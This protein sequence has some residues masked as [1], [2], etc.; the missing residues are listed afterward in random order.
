MIDRNH[1]NRR[2]PEITVEQL[3]AYL[4]SKQW[5]EDGKIRSVA[6]IWHRW[7]DDDS[8]VL[9]PCISAKDYL[10][11]I[12][13]A[14][15]SL[16]VYEKRNLADVIKDIRQILSNVITVRIV[17]DDTSDGTIPIND[18]VLLIAK[19]KEL[20]SAAAQSVYA[21]RKQFTGAVPKEAKEY[22]DTLLLGQTEVGSYI[23][24]IIAPAQQVTDVNASTA[25]AVPLGQ[26][27]TRNLVTS[28]EAL[29]LASAAYEEGGDLRTFDAAV[30]SGAS[31]NMCDALLGFSGEKHHREFEITVTSASV[32]M[33]ES[34]PRKFTFASRHVELLE[35]VSDYYKDDYVLTQCRLIGYITKLSRPKD[36]TS[37]TIVIDS[38]LGEIERK[39]RV[40]LAGD[41]YHMAVL[42]HDNSKLVRVDG[43]VH[44]KSKS[45][46]LL[47]PVNFGV[48]ENEDLF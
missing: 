24:N 30:R 43:D 8:E 9:V 6:T 7:D 48:I 36:E 15:L 40:E 1:L 45:A 13:Q 4:G 33:F 20:L 44:I 17:H 47:N 29:E 14:L 3:H 39:V 42:A 23:V 18:G 41:D 19:A 46:Q 22:L 32:P 35:K 31:S 10:P 11:R 37:G 27:V 26:V 34:E 2:D 16:A 12:R 5:H 21:K 28:L 38:T 25:E